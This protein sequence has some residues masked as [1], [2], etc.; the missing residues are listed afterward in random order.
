MNIDIE[1]LK[2]DLGY[3]NSVAPE[4]AEALI[5]E[6][7]FAKWD[8]DTELQYRKGAWRENTN[9]WSIQRYKDAGVH[10]IVE[11]P[12][13]AW[14]GSG[15]PP[16]GVECEAWFAANEWVKGLIVAHDEVDGV[17][18]AVF[19]YGEKYVGFTSCCLRPLKTE[20]ERVV[21][22]ALALDEYPRGQSAGGMMS[23]KDF[24]AK[25][26]DVGALKMPGG[27]V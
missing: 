15:L 24:C 23:R 2:T 4:G 25:L 13:P 19:R 6:E 17:K 10:D 20:K 12:S 8:G 18:V 11:R 22:A 9:P 26:Y 5:D 27:E 7:L 1:R 16:V 3:W 14:D 21:E